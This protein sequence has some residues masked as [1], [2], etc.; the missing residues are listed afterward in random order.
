[1]AQAAEPDGAAIRVRAWTGGAKI[2]QW[3]Y[4]IAGLLVLAVL[5]WASDTITLQNERTVYTADCARGAWQGSHCAGTL[6]AGPRYRFRALRAHGEVLFW[7]VRDTQPSGKLVPCAITDG[8]NWTCSP[9]AE[10]GRTITLQMSHG[11]PVALAGVATKPFHG[12]PKW[13]WWL[14]RWG[15]V[16]SH[17]A[18]N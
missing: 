2:R 18:A 4:L 6:V 13:R 1:M 15:I 16:L 3:L 5:G 11:E 14:L 10:P 17:D 12:V 9:G 8:R 7:T